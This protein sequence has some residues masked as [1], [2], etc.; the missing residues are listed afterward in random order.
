[1]S[2]L[3]TILLL[4]LLRWSLYCSISWKEGLHAF[5]VHRLFMGSVV[6]SLSLL[7]AQWGQTPNC[8]DQLDG[9]WKLVALMLNC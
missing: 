5:P 9:L 8:L 3:G 2:S 7:K 6:F 1:M 4:S